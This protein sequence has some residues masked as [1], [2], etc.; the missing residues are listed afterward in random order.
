MPLKTI[1][2]VEIFSAGT[3]NGDTYSNEDLDAMVSAFNDTKS[4]FRP[5]LKLGHS[6]DQKLL[7]QDGMPAAGWIGNLKREGEKLIAD[8]VDIPEKIYQLLINKAYRKVSS[9]IYHNID[10]IGQKFSHMLSGVALLGSDLPAVGTLDDILK[11]YG[12]EG[13]AK[14]YEV[15]LETEAEKSVY[16]IDIS[17]EQNKMDYEK[18]LIELK[19]K[20]E[21]LQ[22]ANDTKEAEL[23]E[24]ESKTEENEKVI[25]DLEKHKAEAEKERKEFALKE[26]AAKRSAFMAEL[27]KDNL[28][29]P[30]MKPLVELMAGNEQKEYSVERTIKKGDDETTETK[31]YS[32]NDLIKETL[33]LAKES[34]VNFE[35]SSEERSDYI[36]ANEDRLEK[37]ID[38]YMEENKSNYSVAY[39]EVMK[40]HN[41]KGE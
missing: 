30:A 11:L 5:N 20:M 40:K 16:N 13:N 25:A 3:W 6:K 29:T 28:V 22:K 15:S 12:I 33:K 19:A 32:K 35:E 9:E 1:K 27:E 21:T 26:A 8:F 41:N 4:K 31:K 24:F 7:Q 17:K 18:E 39:S 14:S 23:K 36:L 2:N 34:E 37:A 10:I 38:K